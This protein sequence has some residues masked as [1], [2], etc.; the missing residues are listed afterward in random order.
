MDSV[1][2][3]WIFWTFWEQKKKLLFDFD[4]DV[5]HTGCVFVSLMIHPLP[6]D[7]RQKLIQLFS[8][9]SR[10]RWSCFS[11]LCRG[12]SAQNAKYSLMSRGLF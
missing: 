9:Q 8:I 11:P 1:S 4:A 6:P 2:L 12:S 5:Q 7:L 10:W 3:K